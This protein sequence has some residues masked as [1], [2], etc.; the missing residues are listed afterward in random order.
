MIMLVPLNACRPQRRVIHKPGD[1]L[2]TVTLCARALRV[3]IKSYIESLFKKPLFPLNLLTSA[4]IKCLI[5]S[6]LFLGLPHSALEIANRLEL[7][8]FTD[9]CYDVIWY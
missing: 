9:G 1:Q 6:S 5:V 8:V 4:F 2:S 3:I 7:S